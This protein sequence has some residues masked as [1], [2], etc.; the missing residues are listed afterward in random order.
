MILNLV[1]G[2]G[3]SKNIKEAT[4]K[5]KQLLE[6]E[7]N[8]GGRKGKYFRTSTAVLALFGD[9]DSYLARKFLQRTGTLYTK[10]PGAVDPFLTKLDKVTEWDDPMEYFNSLEKEQEKE[11]Q[12]QV[13]SSITDSEI[14]QQQIKELTK[15]ILTTGADPSSAP[16]KSP[17]K[18]LTENMSR[19]HSQ[20]ASSAASNKD[21]HIPDEPKRKPI[22]FLNLFKNQPDAD[23]FPM[24][25]NKN[26][27]HSTENVNSHTLESMTSP[28]QTP[29]KTRSRISSPFSSSFL[30][31]P[32]KNSSTNVFDHPISPS[33]R[34]L[35]LSLGARNSFSQ[36]KSNDDSSFNFQSEPIHN[37]TQSQSQIPQLQ[38][39]RPSIRFLSPLETVLQEKL[40]QKTEIEN[41]QLAE[42]HNPRF[43]HR[44][45]RKNI[46]QT[47]PSLYFQHLTKD[48]NNLTN[49]GG[50]PRLS[51]ASAVGFLMNEE[52]LTLQSSSVESESVVSL[53]HN[54]YAEVPISLNAKAALMTLLV[55]KT[56]KIYKNQIPTNQSAQRIALL[57]GGD[58]SFTSHAPKRR[59]PKK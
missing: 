51:S 5:A 18:P 27:L 22:D 33:K 45:P 12:E 24:G 3:S 15:F 13:K 2:L 37:T 44:K 52:S 4:R 39:R 8:G 49:H 42:K 29:L 20:R 36:K 56:T 21:G 47:R 23:F 46:Q 28:L 34:N 31:S 43:Y 32:H 48:H 9:T 35:S 19:P 54:D 17:G 26:L 55:E 30:N 57:E 16:T 11:F 59:K 6:N 53:A 14:S 40:K 41:N 7:S 1:L 10:V 50:I 38:Q 58:I 25:K